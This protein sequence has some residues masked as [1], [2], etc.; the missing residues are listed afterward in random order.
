MAINLS[1]NL[2]MV[3]LYAVNQ[4]DKFHPLSDTII[5]ITEGDATDEEKATQVRWALSTASEKHWYHIEKVMQYL[6]WDDDLS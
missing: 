6:D 1:E 3:N 4:G 5:D 2:T